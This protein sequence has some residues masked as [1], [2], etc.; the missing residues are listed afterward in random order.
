MRWQIILGSAASLSR[1][2]ED[3][4]LLWYKDLYGVKERSKRPRKC[5]N[6]ATSAVGWESA[7]LYTDRL[8]QHENMAA[9]RA[10]LG[11]IRTEFHEALED[12]DWMSAASREAAKVKLASMFFQVGVPTDA[13][14]Q[15]KWPE[16]ARALEGRLG[17]NYFVNTE[18]SS[19][20]SIERTMRELTEPTDRR[21]WGGS[22]PLEVNAFY[23]PSSNG[24]WIPAG[25]L[26][27]PFFSF[28]NTDARNYGAI[29]TILGHEM[30]HG[31]DDDGRQYD[32][33]G[34]L[35]DWWDEPTVEGFKN[36]STCLASLFGSYAVMGRKVNG[37]LTLGE[38]IADSGGIKFA[39]RAFLRAG[40]PAGRTD[41]EK[42]LFFTSFAQNWCEVDRTKSALS[43]V[44]TDEH[45]PGKFRVIGG[46]TQFAPFADAF[47]C[48]V[49][50]P[51]APPDAARCHLW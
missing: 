8:F 1:P 46:M 41:S 37:V 42:R 30:S 10:M 36:R 40:G 23:G 35:K 39:Y 19:R 29:G 27:D 33:R 2:F 28:K 38:D 7:K 44:L 43:S 11:A 34:V 17:P 4:L 32:A 26:Q 9:A 6:S 12:A 16:R 18:I 50:S 22:T 21:S 48:P 49:G 14:D 47:Q 5:F 51:M 20:V 31:F 24:L 3:E 25:V 13:E 45:A 15:V